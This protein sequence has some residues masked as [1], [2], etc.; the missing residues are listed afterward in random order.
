ME[1]LLLGT[2]AADGIPAYFAESRLSSLARENG[3]KDLRLRSSALIDG[4]LKI[5]FGPDTLAQCYKFKLNPA[6]WTDIVFTHSHDDHFAPPIFG[7]AT[8]R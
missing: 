2:G 4:K 6:E 5:D 3:G 8:I 1:L 7:V